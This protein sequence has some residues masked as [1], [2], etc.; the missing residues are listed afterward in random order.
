MGMT[1]NLESHHL[2]EADWDWCVCVPEVV[3]TV[4]EVTELAARQWG[5]MPAIQPMCI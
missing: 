1:L 5:V 4:N 3:G 2:Y